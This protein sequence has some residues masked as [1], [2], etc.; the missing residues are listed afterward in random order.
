M[1]PSVYST[2]I[3]KCIL[4]L[5][6]HSPYY[7]ALVFHWQRPYTILIRHL[8]ATPYCTPMGHLLIMVTLDYINVSFIYSIYYYAM[9]TSF[10]FAMIG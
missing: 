9:I 6:L 5:P 2:N 10:F 7:N 3:P 4:R 8:M 1:W